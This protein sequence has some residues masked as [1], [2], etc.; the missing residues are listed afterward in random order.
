[1]VQGRIILSPGPEKRGPRLL[2]VPT[3]NRDEDV[4]MGGRVEQLETEECRFPAEESGPL[5]IGAVDGAELV[6]GLRRNPEFPNAEIHRVAHLERLAFFFG[7]PVAFF[8]V[9]LWERSFTR[10]G[11][12]APP[13]SRFHSSNVCGEISPFTSS[14]ANLRRWALLLNGIAISWCVSTEQVFPHQ[15]ESS[16]RPQIRGAPETSSPDRATDDWR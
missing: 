16:A 1:M 13:V 12:L 9:L 3:I 15:S 2:A 8:L 14:S 4:G 7:L 10:S 6:D 11:S 5:S